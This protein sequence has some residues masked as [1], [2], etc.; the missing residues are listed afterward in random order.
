MTSSF[1]LVQCKSEDEIVAVIAHELGHWKLNHTTYSFIAVQVSN[2]WLKRIY[3]YLHHV[4]CRALHV[5]YCRSLPS[6]NLEDT[7]LSETQLISSG[8]LDLIHNQSSLVWSYF[9]F[10]IFW[11]WALNSWIKREFTNN[12]SDISCLVFAAH[13]NTTS[14]SSKLWPQPR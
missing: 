1:F 5:F 9:R 8:V 2:D 7:P 10:V 13:C 6:C 12:Q 14:T 4:L 3:S 11:F